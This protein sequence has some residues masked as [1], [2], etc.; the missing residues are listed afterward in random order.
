[1]DTFQQTHIVYSR[2]TINPRLVPEF[3]EHLSS[4]SFP[5]C[6]DSRFRCVTLAIHSHLFLAICFNFSNNLLKTSPLNC[7]F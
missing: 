5:Q 1:M 6:N 3:G 4:H 7:T 2:A